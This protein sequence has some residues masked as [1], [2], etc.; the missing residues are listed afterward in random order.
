MNTSPITTW[1]GATA[2]FTFAN[3][4]TIMGLLIAAMTLVTLYGIYVAFAAESKSYTAA[5]SDKG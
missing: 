4:P 1:E 5:R 2:Y 3:N